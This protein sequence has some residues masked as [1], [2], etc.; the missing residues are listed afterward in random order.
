VRGIGVA[1]QHQDVD[2]FALRGQRQPFAHP[3]TM[4]FVDHRQRQRLE[5]HVVLDQ[6][7]GADQ[8][9]DLAGLKPRQQFAP[10]LALFRGR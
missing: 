4:L 2:R 5:H 1:P 7:M 6:R 10:L 3:K 8:Q 9:I